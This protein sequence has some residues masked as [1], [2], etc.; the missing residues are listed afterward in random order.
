MVKNRR[1]IDRATRT[2]DGRR[3]AGDQASSAVH[4]DALTSAFKCNPGEVK[5]LISMTA[6]LLTVV[7]HPV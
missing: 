5:A 4:E 2:N 1:T 6:V 3:S 7:D